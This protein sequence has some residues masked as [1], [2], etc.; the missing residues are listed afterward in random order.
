MIIFLTDRNIRLMLAGYMLIASQ[1][2]GI[3]QDP[4]TTQAGFKADLDEVVVSASRRSEYLSHVAYPVTVVGRREIGLFPAHSPD[5]IFFRVGGINQDRKN[6]LFSGSKNTVNL[7]G[8]TGGEQ[9]RVL[10]LEDGIPLNVSDN[11][12]VNWNRFDL[13]DYAQVEIIR[14]PASSL[15][16]SNALGGIINL[17]SREPQQP[18]ELKARL[19]YGS[20]NT[21]LGSVSLSGTKKK[22]FWRAAFNYNRGDGYIMPPDSL[23]DSTDVP[24]FL[25][26]AGLRLKTGYRVNQYLTLEAS[27]IFYDDKHGYGLRL[28]DPEG[29]YSS[30]RTHFGRVGLKYDNHEWFFNLNLFYQQEDYYKLIEKLK[31]TLYSA[32]DVFSDRGDAGIM[33]CFGKKSARYALSL[34]TDIRMGSTRASDIFR[35]SADVIRNEGRLYQWSSFFLAESYL[36]EN[37]FRLSGSLGYSLVYLK[38]GSFLLEDPTGETDYM[39]QFTGTLSD[40]VWSSINPSV[41][42]RFMPDKRWNI[43]LSYAHGFRSPAIDDLT[44]SGMTNIGFKEANPFLRPE[45]INTIQAGVRFEPG[46]P[47]AISASAFYS[48]GHDYIYFFDTGETLF[49]GK[50]KVYRKD[51]INEVEATGAEVGLSWQPAEWISGYAHIALN[52]SVIRKNEVLEGKYLS[53]TPGHMEGLGLITGNRW[54]SGAVY[55]LFKGKQYMDDQNLQAVEPFTDINLYLSATLA[56][57]YKI[58]ARVQNLLDK[59]YFFDERNLSLGRFLSAGLELVF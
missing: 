50:R 17:V 41:S 52:R 24:T 51:N 47:V 22:F 44:R 58:S 12:E 11:G 1:A 49:N 4:D 9:G 31:G 15:Y 55:F 3:C 6:G 54:L 21:L 32:I 46:I 25:E 42:L 27:Y 39:T 29:G 8:I 30:H 23:R 40:T 36:M 28:R 26:E 56:K 45:R 7:M 57:H 37:R 59:K 2:T 43:L 18:L 13:A 5:D 16:G 53:Y 14:G 10:V 38:A 20:Y 35:T 48:R 33:S 19:S 34:G